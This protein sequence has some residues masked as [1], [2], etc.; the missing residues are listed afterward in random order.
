MVQLFSSRYA[1]D[2]PWLILV[3][4]VFERFKPRSTRYAP[5]IQFMRIEHTGSVDD[6]IREF[7]RAKARLLMQAGVK[8]DFFFTW[9]FVSRLKEYIQKPM[10][11]FKPKSLDDA[12]NVALEM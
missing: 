4:A 8:S 2:P 7:Q 10:S 9:A 3:D 11:L 6:Y 12:F 1:P 5:V